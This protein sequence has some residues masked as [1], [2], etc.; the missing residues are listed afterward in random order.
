MKAIVRLRSGVGGWNRRESSMYLTKNELE[1]MDVLWEQGRPLARG[2][3]L[4]LP[5]SKT[6]RAAQKTKTLAKHYILW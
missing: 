3:L 1:I 2:E 5:E 6:G 4:S